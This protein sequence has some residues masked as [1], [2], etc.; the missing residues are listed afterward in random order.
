MIQTRVIDV[1]D[2]AVSI[3]RKWDDLVEHGKLDVSASYVWTIAL[4]E[5]HLKKKNMNIILVERGNDILGIFPVFIKKKTINKI[6]VKTICLLP[7]LFCVHND[8]VVRDDKPEAL[9][10]FFNLINNHHDY[11]NW[12]VFE[13]PSVVT[14][15]ST[16][17]LLQNVLLSL[18][19][20]HKILQGSSSPFLKMKGLSW[21]KYLR[22]RSKNSRKNF[23]RK[24]NTIKNAGGTE[25]KFVT[26]QKE[27]WKI[28]LEIENKS[29]KHTAGFSIVDKTHQM[30]FYG[31]L[32]N[33]FAEALKF[34]VLFFGKR[35]ITYCM[36]I[37]HRKKYWSLKTS[38]D[39]EFKKLSPGTVLKLWLLKYCFDIH[40]EE[41]DFGGEDEEHK[42]NF[43]DS[44][45]HHKNYLIFNSNMYSRTVYRISRLTENIYFNTYDA[46][47][48][49]PKV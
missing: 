32:I 16:D 5:S 27:I 41:F 2:N 25:M 20:P 7:N 17:Q 1:Y 45:C 26:D 34:S 4:W 18:R 6:P 24:E 43:T 46:N 11:R 28:L 44:V 29:W 31:L 42:L 13:I 15:S 30:A 37:L 49:T 21:E 48:Q 8:L 12:N 33:E 3:K 36:G 38:Y 35:P 9:E 47:F 23:K 19:F 14:N 10:A 40:L 22:S 39:E